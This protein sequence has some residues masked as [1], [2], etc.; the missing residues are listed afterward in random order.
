MGQ[1]YT[2]KSIDYIADIMAQRKMVEESLKMISNAE[3]LLS[4]AVGDLR[5]IVVRMFLDQRFKT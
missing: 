1:V 3:I 2:F 5:E 4:K